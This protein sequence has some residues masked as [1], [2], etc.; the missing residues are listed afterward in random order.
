MEEHLVRNGTL[1]LKFF[2]HL[3]RQEQEK[4]FLERLDDPAKNW[5]F[6]EADL[7][8]RAYWD[9]YMKAYEQMLSHT[10]TQHAPWYIVPADH[11]WFTHSERL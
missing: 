6:S 4:R 7:H 3:S 10:S 9:H 1:I 11:K 5:K 8:E 2:L